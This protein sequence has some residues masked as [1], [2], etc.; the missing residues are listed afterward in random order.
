MKRTYLVLLL[1]VLLGATVSAREVVIHDFDTDENL[2]VEAA[3]GGILELFELTSDGAIEG[4]SSAALVFDLTTP[5]QSWS[6]VQVIIDCEKPMDIDGFDQVKLWVHGDGTPHNVIILFWDGFLEC[7]VWG[8]VGWEGWH[9]WVIDLAET[10]NKWNVENVRLDRVER[11]RIV[12][13]D[14]N[15]IYKTKGKILVDRLAVAFGE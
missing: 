2:R 6:E 10:P 1:V 11:V 12:I 14:S 9:E 15:G 5:D 4:K 8:Q 13:S 3:N 7:S